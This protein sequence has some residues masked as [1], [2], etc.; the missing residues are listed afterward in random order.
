MNNYII[1]PRII[2]FRGLIQP[3]R[4]TFSLLISIINYVRFEIFNFEN[5]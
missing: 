3:R 5:Y 4:H 2:Q 1:L